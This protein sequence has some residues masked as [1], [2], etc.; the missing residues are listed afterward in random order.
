MITF[1]LIC[2]CKYDIFYTRGDL[3]S[4]EHFTLDLNNG[5]QDDAQ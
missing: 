5:S 1:K 3:T 2:S 4:A